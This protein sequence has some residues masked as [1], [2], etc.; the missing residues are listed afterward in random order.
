MGLGEAL[1]SAGLAI[2]IAQ[3]RLDAELGGVRIVALPRSDVV[4]EDDRSFAIAEWALQ[5]ENVTDQN[6]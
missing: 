2:A 4:Q 5:L 1:V 3:R 6:E